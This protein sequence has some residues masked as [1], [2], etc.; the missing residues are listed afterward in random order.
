MM[1]CPSERSTPLVL[2]RRMDEPLET[3][4]ERERTSFI[5]YASTQTMRLK[6]DE[7]IIG[8]T[9][10]SHQTLTLPTQCYAVEF[11]DEFVTITLLQ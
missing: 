5:E 1:P 10:K 2:S 3:V 8:N 4:L 6:S 9:I 7:A 11:N